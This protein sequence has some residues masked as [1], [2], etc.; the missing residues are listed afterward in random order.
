MQVI[1]IDEILK[2]FSRNS[3]N[4]LNLEASRFFF[5]HRSDISENK[6]D[7]PFFFS[8]TAWSGLLIHFLVYV[9]RHE[10]QV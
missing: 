5:V 3:G 9:S 2:F 10:I 8:E 7:T 4:E 6:D 1:I